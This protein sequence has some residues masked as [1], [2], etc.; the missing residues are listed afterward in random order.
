[1]NTVNLSLDFDELQSP[2]E[3]QNQLRAITDSQ[4]LLKTLNELAQMPP[5]SKSVSTSCT[6]SA[7]TNGGGT[8]S[9]TITFTPK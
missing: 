2:E 3:I 1:M 8:I 9:C 4:D 5:E 6:G 7:S